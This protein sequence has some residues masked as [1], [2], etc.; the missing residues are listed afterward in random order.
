[1]SNLTVSFYSLKG[2][3]FDGE[4]DTVVIPGF[5]G[6]IG[7]ISGER[8]LT[9]LIKPGILYLI[10]G[11]KSFKR[12]F[13]FGGRFLAHNNELIITTEYE[14]LDVDK[15]TSQDIEKRINNVKEKVA[16]ASNEADKNYYEFRLQQENAL[17]ASYKEKFY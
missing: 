13:V 15:I 17:L 3:L 4:A 5:N 14:V 6:D 8:V 10:K 1:M 11:D 2:K 12:F 7:V 16:K 9:Y